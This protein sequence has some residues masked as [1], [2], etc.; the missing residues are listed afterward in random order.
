[1]LSLYQFITTLVTLF[2]VLE[3]V[4]LAGPKLLSKDNINLHSISI[5]GCT[6]PFLKCELNVVLLM[7][8]GII[9]V[10]F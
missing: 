5:L 3:K 9:F 8:Y 7:F 1:M 4:W 2:H 6:T 10:F